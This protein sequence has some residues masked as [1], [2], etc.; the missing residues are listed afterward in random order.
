LWRIV[1]F[2]V[3]IRHIFVVGQVAAGGGGGQR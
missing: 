3:T 1:T 2:S